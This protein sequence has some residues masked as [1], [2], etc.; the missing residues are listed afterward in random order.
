[1]NVEFLEALEEMAKEEGIEREE[2]YD[3]VKKGLTAAYIEKFGAAENLEVDIDRSSGD[4]TILANGKSVDFDLSRLGRIATR[5]AE[6]TIKQEIVKR[7][8]QKIYERYHARVGELINGSVHRF[9]GRDVWLNLGQAEAFLAEEERIPGEHYR[10]GQVLRT[11]LYRAEETP[12]DPRI[13]V[14]RAHPDF[15]RQLL[16]LE[17]PEIEKGLV[18]IVAIAREPGVRSKVAVRARSPE[19][20]P[21]GTCVGASGSRVREVVKE[22]SGEKIDIIRWSEDVRDLIK[23]SLE[24]ASVI[25]IELDEPQ[26]K[27]LVVVPDNELSLAIGKGGQNVRLTAKLTGWDIEVTSPQELEGGQATP[28]GE[29]VRE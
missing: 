1:M 24:P 28:S 17:V 26:K 21:V 6:E 20:E 5:R 19:I 13:L 22:L 14:S 15:V 2:L 4:I 27:A 8:R 16:K 23:N 11:Y 12:G 18:E 3:A 10:P 7:R 25:R 29:A 9:E